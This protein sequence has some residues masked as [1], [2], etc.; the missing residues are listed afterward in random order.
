MGV[1]AYWQEDEI[2]ETGSHQLMNTCAF[3][4]SEK[5]RPGSGDMACSDR[6]R[7]VFLCKCMRHFV[8]SLMLVLYFYPTQIQTQPHDDIA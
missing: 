5:G 7:W 8:L 1:K 2:G 6:P 3:R 4:I